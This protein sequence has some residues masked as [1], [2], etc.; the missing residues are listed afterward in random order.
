MGHIQIRDFLQ[1]VPNQRDEKVCFRYD[2]Y[3]N[4]S[5]SELFMEAKDG[6]VI[7]LPPY[8]NDI[9]KFSS[10]DKAKNYFEDMKMDLSR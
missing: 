4:K 1:P 8:F 10:I 6:S 3:S 5:S 7:Y 9:Q 2:M